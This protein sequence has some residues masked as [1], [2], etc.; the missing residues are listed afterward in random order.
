MIKLFNFVSFQL[1]IIAGRSDSLADLLSNAG[2]ADRSNPGGND[3]TGNAGDV[4][5]VTVSYNRLRQRVTISSGRPAVTPWPPK[6]TNN[7]RS[8]IEIPVINGYTSS[9]ASWLSQEEALYREGSTNLGFVDISENPVPVQD[10]G[11]AG[12]ASDINR[13]AVDQVWASSEV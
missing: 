2:F 9:P 8:G 13:P 5:T 12:V 11:V 10:S 7:G 4:S 6:D 1:P 3:V